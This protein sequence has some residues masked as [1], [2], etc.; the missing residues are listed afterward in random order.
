MKKNIT[1]SGVDLSYC[2][3]GIDYDALKKSGAEFALIR[4]G[5]RGSSLCPDALL[6]KHVEGC[7]R[8]GIDYGFYWFAGS[9][10]VTQAREEA[11]AC[12]KYLDKFPKPKYPVFY[13]L[14]E[15]DIALKGRRKCTDMVLAFIDEIEKRGYPG[16]LYTNPNWLEHFLYKEY[17]VGRQDIWLAHYTEDCNCQYGQTVWQKG[18]M[19]LNG[20]PVDE[21]ECFVNYPEKTAEWYKKHGVS[22]ANSAGAEKNEP[23]NQNADKKPK[24]KTVKQLA[25][26]VIRGDWGCGAERKRRLTEAGYD[27]KAV[28]DEVNRILNGGNVN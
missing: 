19:W 24:R 27:Y 12:A 15:L 20:Q 21:D 26:E 1:V 2:Q 6:E 7:I 14:E 8:V 28:Q 4:A 22:S 5:F 11:R 13:D 23:E 10:N 16:G 9:R 17:L 3:A 18:I 25:Q